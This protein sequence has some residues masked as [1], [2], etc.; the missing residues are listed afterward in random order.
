M[1]LGIKT[2]GE[3]IY[4]SLTI[5]GLSDWFMFMQEV[6]T[7]LIVNV[8]HCVGENRVQTTYGVRENR[9]WWIL[10]VAN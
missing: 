7:V 3:G 1:R 4:A 5:H 8:C 2:F 6:P 10:N 9:C